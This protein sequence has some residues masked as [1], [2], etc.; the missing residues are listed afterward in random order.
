MTTARTL[1]PITMHRSTDD[2]RPEL[3]N[4]STIAHCLMRRTTIDVLECPQEDYEAWVT[5]QLGSLHPF[6]PDY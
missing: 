1:D 3:R 5:K 2:A 6:P 4:G